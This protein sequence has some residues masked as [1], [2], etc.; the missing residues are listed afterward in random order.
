M[1]PRPEKGYRV[2]DLVLGDDDDDGGDDDD[3]DADDVCNV[4]ARVRRTE[5]DAERFSDEAPAHKRR[6]A[7][8]MSFK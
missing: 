7:S 4:G 1:A 6:R 8:T 3:D 2:V 5:V